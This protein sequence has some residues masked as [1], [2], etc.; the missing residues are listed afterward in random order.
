MAKVNPFRKRWWL[1]IFDAR[2]VVIYN[3]AFRTW[4]GAEKQG[5]AISS[6]PL[7]HYTVQKVR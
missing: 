7:N 1:L 5:R 3:E 2:N 4:W 6:P